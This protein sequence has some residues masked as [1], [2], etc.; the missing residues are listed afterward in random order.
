[1]TDFKHYRQQLYYSLI[2]VIYYKQ[3]DGRGVRFSETTSNRIV[4][5][6]WNR[7]GHLYCRDNVFV[8]AIEDQILATK[9]IKSSKK[10][11]RLMLNFWRFVICVQKQQTTSKSFN[12]GLA[13]IPRPYS[14]KISKQ[15]TIYC[16]SIRR[17]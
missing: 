15:A 14:H 4:L 17:R 9:F 1:M 2:T 16:F 3:L 8:P 10:N 12:N 6:R 5:V 11:Q 13:K 7:D